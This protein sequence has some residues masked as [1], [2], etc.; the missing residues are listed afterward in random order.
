MQRASRQSIHAL[1]R[2]DLYP[3]PHTTI[4][5]IGIHT[6][7]QIAALLL[8]T[9]PIFTP[10]EDPVYV[11]IIVLVADRS[12]RV[13]FTMSSPLKPPAGSDSTLSQYFALATGF[14]NDVKRLSTLHHRSRIVQ[15]DARVAGT[16]CR[17]GAKQLG[18]ELRKAQ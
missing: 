12:L 16:R 14:Q 3:E 1:T 18:R 13:T 17:L 2:A 5:R 11:A 4:D 10:P 9:V 6:D 8:V 7:N 15:I